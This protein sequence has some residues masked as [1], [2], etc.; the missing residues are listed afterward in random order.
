MPEYEL[1][2]SAYNRAESDSWI[3]LS[4]LPSWCRLFSPIKT[5]RVLNNAKLPNGFCDYDKKI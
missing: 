1:K 2:V 4:N 3:I 5:T